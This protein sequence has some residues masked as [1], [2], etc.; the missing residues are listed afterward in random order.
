M[1][2]IGGYSHI[3][4]IPISAIVAIGIVDNKASLLL[5]HRITN[6]NPNAT[7][8]TIQVSHDA[9]ETNAF[10]LHSKV[11]SA[12][13]PDFELSEQNKFMA[14]Q[15][16]GR[17]CVAVVTAVNGKKWLLGTKQAPLILL[18]KQLLPGD[19][20]GYTGIELNLSC[21]SS[22]AILEIVPD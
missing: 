4:I 7:P 19:T 14:F 22:V 6:W 1:D 12:R 15:L 13:I 8:E 2:N 5:S 17:Q 21:T 18:A 16:S 9:Q 10:P 20:S 3:E 11:A